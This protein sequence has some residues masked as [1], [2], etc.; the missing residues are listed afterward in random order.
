MIP[1]VLRSSART[2]MLAVSLPVLLNAC[3]GDDSV[4]VMGA[5]PNHGNHTPHTDIAQGIWPPQPLGITNEQLLPSSARERVQDNVI[6]AARSIVMNN[7]HVRQALG[8]NFITADGSLGDAKSETTATFLFFS[9]TFNH[10][11]EVTLS[12]SGEVSHETFSAFAYQPAEQSEERDRAI[13]LANAALIS[14]GFETSGLI[15]TAILANPR[16]SESTD[17]GRLFHSQRLLYVTFGVG[18]GELPEFSA[19]VNLSTGGVSEE[20]RIR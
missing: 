12:R 20:G 10:T 16:A 11:V 5:L 8:S 2:L 6:E 14:A 19:L 9:Y 13:N 7:P 15:G 17:H 3:G 18:D 1:V 4:T